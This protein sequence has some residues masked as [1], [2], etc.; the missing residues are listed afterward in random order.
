MTREEIKKNLMHG[1]QIRVARKLGTHKDYVNQVLNDKKRGQRGKGKLIL[2][3]LQNLAERNIN[4][5]NN[6]K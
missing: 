1:D 6:N 3:E 5:F 2:E 4:Y